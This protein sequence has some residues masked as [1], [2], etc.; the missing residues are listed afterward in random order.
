MLHLRTLGTLC[1]ERDDGSPTPLAARKLGLALLALVSAH[2]RP[3]ISRDKLLAYLWPESDLQH[4][5]NCLKQTIFALRRAIGDSV[6]NSAG[7]L[8]YLDPA[9][10]TVDLWDFQHAR[11][12]ADAA[13]AVARYLGPFLD[14]FYL[15]GRPEFEG[16]VEEERQRLS[17][18]FTELLWAQALEAEMKGDFAAAAGWWQRLVAADPLSSKAALGY[19]RAL[20]AVGDIT[21]A[22][23]HARRHAETVRAELD[24][25]IAEEIAALANRLRTAVS[26]R[27][28]WGPPPA[29]VL[30]PS[31]RYT[32]ASVPALA[33][34]PEPLVGVPPAQS[35]RTGWLRSSLLALLLIA[36]AV[37]LVSTS[38]RMA[39]RPT[40]AV[41]GE[42]AGV[43]VLPFTVTGGP[44][45]L[46]LGAGLED[47]LA[48]RLDGAGGLRSLRITA[49]QDQGLGRTGARLDAPAGA[50]VA[51]RAVARL[52]V[53]GRVVGGG[54]RLE[55]TAVMYDRGNANA[56][57]ARAEAAV[58]ETAVFELAD[59]L[60]AQLIAGFHR[61]P[62]HGL[63]WDAASST[64]SLPALKA[65]LEGE[66]RLR[67]DSFAGAVDAFRQAVRADT[68][69]A[70]AHYQLSVAANRAGRNEVALGAA[71]LAIRFGE[72]LSEHDLA[73]TEAFLV[74]R[75]GRIGDAERRYRRIL[76]EY[77]E[78]AEGWFQL[79][80]VLYHS[81]PL[82]GRSVI[83]ARPGLERVLALDP[84]D[85]EALLHLARIAALEG[86][87]KEADSLAGLALSKTPDSAGLSLAV[88]RAYGLG[89]RPGEDQDV[90][91]TA[92]LLP[93]RALLDAALSDDNVAAGERV[94]TLLAQEATSCEL[95]GVARR[96]LAQARLA[97]GRP[98][99]A[100]TAL[101]APE[102]CD[103]TASLELRAVYQTLPFAPGNRSRLSSLLTELETS[104]PLGS[105]LSR[106]D[107]LVGRYSVGLVALAA[108]DTALARRATAALSAATK[109]TLEE[110]LAH[111]LAHSLL[112][113][114]ALH[115][116]QLARGL[117]LLERAQWE[118]NPVPTIAETNDRFLRA[119]LLYQLGRDEEAAGWYRSIAERSSHEL[120]YLAPAQY[121]LGQIRDRQSGHRD[122][123]AYYRRFVD[124]WRDSEPVVPFLADAK[125]RVAELEVSLDD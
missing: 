123:L 120:V 78:D 62:N 28:R 12:S 60:A 110:A 102:P 20:D 108:G 68:G 27:S 51:R 39:R 89:D 40:P 41:P 83:E 66:R 88:S 109:S 24:V 7:P 58:E 10:I 63:S 103:I 48:A 34:T 106:H 87:R 119:E 124:L 105:A 101:S 95:R 9:A 14:G 67:A 122:A 75:R 59:A 115:R 8:L 25:P 81:N 77:P 90:V 85:V 11:G 116:G 100:L 47:L 53:I 3:G 56:P 92:G 37:S 45:L 5:R 64:R 42:A 21:G 22:L 52:Y 91:A 94:A 70:L 2:G 71:E 50:A 72:R 97:R 65:Y 96:M 104:W 38:P 44:A 13:A 46:D 99:A 18:S 117:A 36:A 93:S 15:E 55:A 113:R 4:A 33:M 84:G 98:E 111:S 54:G 79:T 23:E 29:S 80:E 61:A 69:F 125:R 121:R 49:R 57:V 82:R 107:T 17:T 31:P 26:S 16:W 32:P 112:A 19:M 73:L 118:R 43:V 1:L 86:K 76:A 30:H 74:L 6:L 35:H 114:L